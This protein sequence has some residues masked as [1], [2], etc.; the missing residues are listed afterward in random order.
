M[1]ES[2]IIIWLK[3]GL[4]FILTIFLPTWP[5]LAILLLAHIVD[6]VSA[7]RLNGRLRKYDPVKFESVRF[8]SYRFST[9]LKDFGFEVIVIFLALGVEA[10]LAT[11]IPIAIYVGYLMIAGQLVSIMENE[12]ECSD[13]KWA[14]WMRRIFKS[15]ANRYLKEKLGIEDEIF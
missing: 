11:T 14:I 9:M 2:A 8:S 6:L 15:K 7:I 4:A 10:L 13:K 12:S 5:V 3:L 1:E